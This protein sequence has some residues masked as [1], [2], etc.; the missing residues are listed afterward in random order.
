MTTRTL[1][2]ILRLKPEPQTTPSLDQIVQPGRARQTV[3]DYR[4]TTTLRD[5]FKR[6][7]ECVVHRK[8]QGFWVQAEYGAGKTHFLGTLLDLLLW[9]KEGVWEA[10]RDD[11]LR[12][13]YAGP[14]AK[15]RLF[16]VAFS[17][18]G[19]GQA[20]GEDSLMRVLEEQVRQSLDALDAELSAKV[21]VTSPEIAAQWYASE[22]TEDEKA[23]VANFFQREHQRT[24]EDFRTKHGL[25]KFGQ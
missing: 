19:M 9:P 21:Q 2:Q 20:E 15:A 6:V 22:A 3:A 12:G 16:P 13:E 25:K 24:P 11:E 4:V 23:G 5:H 14:L 7:F 1:K 10:V 18:R 17:L 8:G